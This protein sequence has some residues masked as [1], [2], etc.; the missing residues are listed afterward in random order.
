MTKFYFVVDRLDLLIQSSDEFSSRGMTI[1][2]IDSK[3]DFTK[4]LNH[5]LLYRVLETQVNT[6]KR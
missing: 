2:P 6:K 4:I 1:A 3:E 5:P